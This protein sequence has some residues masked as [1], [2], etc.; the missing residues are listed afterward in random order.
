M[1]LGLIGESLEHSFSK[2]FFSEKFE[3]EGL[4]HRYENFEL[5]QISDFPAL[6]AQQPLRGLNVTIP[7]KTAILPYLDELDAAA[8]AIGAVNTLVFSE[9]GSIKGYNTDVIGFRQSLEKALRAAALPKPKE[10][11]VLGTGGAA[12]AVVFVLKQLG[13]APKLVSRSPQR[14]DY[15]YS[16]LKTLPLLVVNTSPVGTFPAVAEAPQLPYDAFSPQH[17][18]FDLIYNPAQTRFL[19]LASAQGA[20]TCNGYEMLVGQALAAWE[21]WR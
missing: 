5:P 2:R 10:A 6:I 19:E 15:T 14:G 17:L 18:A 8:E 11:L 12:Q 20:H 4:P 7:Y 21:L 1:L 16:D 9:K 3:K 13:I